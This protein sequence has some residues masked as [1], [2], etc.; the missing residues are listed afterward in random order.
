MHIEG[1]IVFNV[2]PDGSI[3]TS[4]D[5]APG[6][7]LND[8]LGFEVAGLVVT[9]YALGDYRISAPGIT[10]PS[11]YRVSVYKDENDE[12]TVRVKLGTA[13]ADL[14]VLVTDPE[15]GSPS[16][17]VYLRTVR[18]AVSGEV[19]YEL[20]PVLSVVEEGEGEQTS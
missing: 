11:G 13:G 18:V 6:V 8:G 19:A 14:Q 12:N 5:H 2:Q 10:W 17:I 4:G 9:R 3:V 16:D 20:P 15:S 1:T 7:S